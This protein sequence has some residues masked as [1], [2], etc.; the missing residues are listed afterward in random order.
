MKLDLIKIKLELEVDL[1]RRTEMCFS[2]WS[3]GQTAN[4]F[5]TDLSFLKP[6]IAIC[7]LDIQ[8]PLKTSKAVSRRC[9]IKK[10][11]L[12]S[13]SK[14]TGKN[15]CWSLLFNKVANLRPATLLKKR[16]WQR[17]FLVRYVKFL[18]TPFWQNTSGRLLLKHLCMTASSNLIHHFILIW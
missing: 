8:I 3:N 17:Y 14:F 7:I 18:R 11:F 4:S 5:L 2:P 12:K 9:P 6:V 13:F 1:E 10:I 15:L 16:L